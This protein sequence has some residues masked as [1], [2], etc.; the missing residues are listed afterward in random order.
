MRN[1]KNEKERKGEKRERKR[2]IVPNGLNGAWV[3]VLCYF[4]THRNFLSIFILS[5]FFF[6]HIY[7]YYYQF[8][9]LFFLE[10]SET[11]NEKKG[12]ASPKSILFFS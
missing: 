10:F 4:S 3:L 12:K 2:E 9:H 6:E 11:K 7:F 1:S 5:L 8:I